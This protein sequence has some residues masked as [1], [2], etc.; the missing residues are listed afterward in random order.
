MLEKRLEYMSK[1]VDYFVIVESPTTFKGNEKKLYFDENKERFKR[2]NNKIIHVK[3]SPLGKDFWD[4]EKNRHQVYDFTDSSKTKTEETWRMWERESQ[5]RYSILDGLYAFD[6]D[7]IIL[8]S[9]VDEI[10]NIE[11]ITSKNVSE[12]MSC[13]M[14]HLVYS[15]RYKKQSAWTGTVVLKLRDLKKSN[16]NYF[17][18]NRWNLKSIENGGRHMTKFMP[19]DQILNIMNNYSHS[20]NYDDLENRIKSNLDYETGEPLLE[21]DIDVP[22]EFKI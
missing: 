1:Y 19:Y 10:P 2:W 6:D 4:T 18:N 14:H 9:D 7:D 20:G 21:S 13:I 12:P 8:I 16:S 17:R 22:Y 11:T 5:Q 15:I 3:T